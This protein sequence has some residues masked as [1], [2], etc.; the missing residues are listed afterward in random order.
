MDAAIGPARHHH[1]ARSAGVQLSQGGFQ[2]FLNARVPGLA[3]PA[4]VGGTVVLK[5]E[6]D[7]PE[8]LGGRAVGQG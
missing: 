5:T 6:G 4:A 3:L 8:L 2:G 7:P 1:G